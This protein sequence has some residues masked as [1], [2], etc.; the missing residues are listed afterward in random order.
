MSTNFEHKLISMSVY[1][2]HDRVEFEKLCNEHN[3]RSLRSRIS[4]RVLNVF[5]DVTGFVKNTISS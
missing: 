3:T 2:S 1:N 5:E 4:D